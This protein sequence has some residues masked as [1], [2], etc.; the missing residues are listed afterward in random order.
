MFYDFETTQDKKC[1]DASYEHVPNLLCVQQFCAVCEDDSDMDVDCWRCGKRKHSFW[2][3]PVGDLISYTFKSRPWADRIVA[4][5]H[6][7]KLFDL[8]FVLTRLVRMKSL[9]ELLIMNG[10]KIMC[11]K[12]E[13][14]TWL[15]SLNYLAMPLKKL[16]ESF[17]L[18]AQKSWHPLPVQ[19][20]G[21]HELCRS[22]ARC[23][24]L[25]HRS[26]ARV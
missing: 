5:A 15:D 3:D 26:D 11:L 2:T 13:N 18:T 23:L 6:N 12:V 9:P 1:G 14:V 4:I 17:G 7:A 19:H 8:L 22:R 24:V 21:E 20:Y 16:P 25:R 10:Q